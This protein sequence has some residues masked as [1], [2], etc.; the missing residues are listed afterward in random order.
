MSG[1]FVYMDDIMV[2]SETEEKH[3]EI[4]EDLLKRLSKNGMAIHLSKC[5][6]KVPSLQFL[7]YE[8]DGKGI[9]PMKKKVDAITN[10]P[11]PKTAKCL[12]GF[13]GSINFYRRAL[14]NINGRTA[15]D[16]LQPLYDF[17]IKKRVGVKFAQAWTTEGMDPHYEN[18][19]E[20][21]RQ[22]AHLTHPDP[23]L[24]LAL[25]TDASQTSVGGVLEQFEDGSWRPMGYFSK[26]LPPQQQRWSTFRRELLAAKEALRHFIAEIDGRHCIIFTDHKALISAFKT[27][28]MKHDVIANN[29]IQEISQ[30]TQDIRFL[31]GRK[32]TVADNLSRPNHVPLGTAYQLGPTDAIG[33]LA[34]TDAESRVHAVEESTPFEIID[35]PA[36]A[37]AQKSCPDVAAHRAR[38][39]PP[40]L[41]FGDHDFGSTT[42]FLRNERKFRSARTASGI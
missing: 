28:S 11:P 42:L 18:A 40:G 2:Y 4:V 26:N 33:P 20:L 24:P 38:K 23:N 8:V 41:F 16:T 9:S 12:L 6:F 17:A 30:W 36:L 21:L 25:T 34:S 31:A 13:L 22:A 14:P 35:R 29:H 10:F 7:G 15:A 27:N 1:V 19:K 37:R 32:N 39:H 5:E 3:L